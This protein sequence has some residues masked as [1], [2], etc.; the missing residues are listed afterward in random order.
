MIV[1]TYSDQCRL[2]L[3]CLPLVKKV[4]ALSLSVTFLFPGNCIV[5]KVEAIRYNV[6]IESP[7]PITCPA[8]RCNCAMIDL[9]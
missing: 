3:V 4:G 8:S 9:R 1:R 6:I 7:Y 2:V 5:R